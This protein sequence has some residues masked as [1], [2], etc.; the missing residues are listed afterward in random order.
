MFE[1][2]VK[3]NVLWEYMKFHKYG[4]FSNIVKSGKMVGIQIEHQ[5][6][7]L[8]FYDKALQFTGKHSNIIKYE[9][10]IKKMIEVE[11]MGLKTL[12]DLKNPFIWFCFSK[13]L[14]EKW[15]EI[16]IVDENINY[17]AMRNYEQKK[18]LDYKNANFWN[19]LKLTTDDRLYLENLNSK[20][21]KETNIK[22]IINNLIVK[23]C[24]ENVTEINKE[25]TSQLTEFLK[26][27]SKH[28]QSENLPSINSYDKGLINTQTHSREQGK[29]IGDENDVKK[30]AK[31]R[32]R[33]CRKS[34]R[35][36]KSNALFCSNACRQK[37]HNHK[38]KMQVEKERMILATLI[39]KNQKPKILLG[40]KYYD[41]KSGNLK[42][43]KGE[44][45][46]FSNEVISRLKEVLLVRTPKAKPQLLTHA[47]ARGL[48]RFLSNR[49]S[50]CIS[51]L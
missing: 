20:Y 9:I 50:E 22:D 41:E 15:N 24:I 3:S 37:Y 12:E 28:L 46:L 8:K 49:N 42:Y 2:P 47:R 35:N 16:I 10:V 13:K 33:D 30:S 1:S 31:C 11:E 45:V 6:Y 43:L 32:C 5:R 18:F 17:K 4:K 51:G 21:Q 29:K 26:P 48:V 25:I 14:I 39:N 36:K 19:N 27:F 7:I 44:E 23:K 40:L 34:L 38:K